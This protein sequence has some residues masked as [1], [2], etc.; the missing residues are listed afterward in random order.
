MTSH[1]TTCTAKGTL[2]SAR[3]N[4]M[5]APAPKNTGMKAFVW[6]S[7]KMQTRMMSNQKSTAIFRSIRPR[8]R[9]SPA[10]SDR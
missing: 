3:K 1:T 6:I 10:R 9:E 5:I 2:A 4:G 8:G 7:A